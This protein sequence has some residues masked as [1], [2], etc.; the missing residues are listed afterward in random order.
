[1]HIKKI[2]LRG[3][4]SHVYIVELTEQ[5]REEWSDSRIIT[6][7]DRKG[8]LSDEEWTKIESGELHPCHFGGSVKLTDD[9]DFLVT[10]YVD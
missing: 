4:S 9:G 2:L 10:V 5:E 6:A 8:N 1:M 7:T 3:S